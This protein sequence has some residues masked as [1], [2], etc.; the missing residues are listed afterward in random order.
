MLLSGIG[1]AVDEAS[2]LAH[3]T[4]ERLLLCS[5]HCYEFARDHLSSHCC[6]GPLFRKTHQ[7]CVL[8]GIFL[9][10]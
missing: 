2:M 1:D 10:K 5:R 8:F 9:S 3:N 4:F 7:S 6:S